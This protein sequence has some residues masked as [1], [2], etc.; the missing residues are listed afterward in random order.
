MNSHYQSEDEI[1]ALVSAFE[2]CTTG[3]DDFKHRD[4]LAVAVWYL[5]NSDRGETLGKMRTGLLRFLQHHQVDT[6]KYKEDL[7]IKWIELVDG[8]LRDLA[9]E[10]PF[11][12]TVNAVID[13]LGD[14][15]LV[16]SDANKDAADL[17]G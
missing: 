12:E 1:A 10:M 13:R 15:G 6:T 17:R 11:V 3:K 14:A 9:P 4:H 8:I 2:N 7:T 16:Q 5:R